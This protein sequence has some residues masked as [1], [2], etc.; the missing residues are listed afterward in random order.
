M[1]VKANKNIHRE[2]LIKDVEFQPE[3]E[4]DHQKAEGWS[5]FN[6]VLGSPRTILAPM[7]SKSDTS[8][9]FLMRK[10]GS[11][12]L[13][14]TPMISVNAASS[15]FDAHGLE[16][17]FTRSHHF[18][19]SQPTTLSREDADTPVVIQ[20][21]GNDPAEFV[22]TANV[23]A[24]AGLCDGFDINFGCPQRCAQR[25]RKGG[26]IA[27]YGS[28]LMNN[29]QLCYNIVRAMHIKCKLPVSVKIRLLD[30][31][32][33]TI[34]FVDAMIKGGAQMV[35]VHCRPQFNRCNDSVPRL[36]IMKTLVE[37]YPSVPFVYN[38]GIGSHYTPEYAL[39]HTGA[40]AVMVGKLFV[41]RPQHFVVGNDG[42]SP[43]QLL[44]I[45]VEYY[46]MCVS[47]HVVIRPLMREFR[48]HFIDL[49]SSVFLPRYWTKIGVECPFELWD[50][51]KQM[52]MRL[53]KSLTNVEIE[54][55]LEEVISFY[56]LSCDIIKSEAVIAVR[57]NNYI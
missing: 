52:M 40:A 6:D 34:A 12:D 5:Y 23:I 24:E 3:I 44:N 26:G 57:K 8:W 25:H 14:F 7:V 10:L 49:L 21:A 27:G 53:S 2:L 56:G 29:W 9:R 31:D 19:G 18:C 22:N 41:F 45:A 50:N 51:G 4:P 48:L 36:D 17:F 43:Q 32:E 33:D 30:E 16:K 11:A 1:N 37:R 42:Y 39:E 55:I 54:E 38:G 46:N 47:K 13:S 20:L 35:T 15:G 28:I